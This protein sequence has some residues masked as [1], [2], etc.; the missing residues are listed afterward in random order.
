VTLLLFAK[1]AEIQSVLSMNIAAIRDVT[2]AHLFVEA[3]FQCYA[4]RV[5]MVM[6]L[7]S[8]QPTTMKQKPM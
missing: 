7:A 3:V 8:F 5:A 1:N 4:F 2:C 6:A